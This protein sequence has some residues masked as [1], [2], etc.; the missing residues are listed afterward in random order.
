[1]KLTIKIDEINYGDVAVKTMPLLEDTGKRYSP[2]IEKTMT[3]IAALPERLIREIFDTIPD[4]QKNDIIAALAMENKGRLLGVMNS[5]LCGQGIGIELADYSLNAELELTAEISRIDYRRIVDKFLP[6]IREKLLDMG[7]A[8]ML[9]RPVIN[10]A[11]AEQICGLMDR[12]LGDRKNAFIASILNQN[13]KT[14][15][16]VIESTA[17]KQGIYLKINTFSLQA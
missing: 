5:V 3:A 16:S 15:I 7:A 12:I 9:L 8:T 2:A 11:S 4:V 1:M 6:A 17:Q 10:A 13:Q 14:L